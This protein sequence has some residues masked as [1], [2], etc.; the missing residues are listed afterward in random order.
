MKLDMHCHTVA[1]DGVNT[2][3]ELIVDAKN[4]WSQALFITDHDRVSLDHVDSIRE[5]GLI[6]V[7][8]VEI[9]TTDSERLWE[10]WK[11]VHMTYY[12]NHYSQELLD[13]LARK[14]R[15]K[16]EFISEFVKFLRERWLDISDEEFYGT[17]YIAK[18]V[19]IN[20]DN[21][22]KLEELWI[23]SESEKERRTL[24]YKWFLNKWWRFYDDFLAERWWEYFKPELWDIAQLVAWKWILSFAHPNFTFES[25]Q[26][27]WFLE[28]YRNFYLPSLWITAIEINT[29][30]SKKWV[31]AIIWLKEDIPNIQL[32]FWSDCH[33]LWKPDDKHWDL[34]FENDFLVEEVVS[35][36]FWNFR[37]RLWI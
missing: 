5:A 18:D 34:W 12:A 27:T 3:D 9:T 23:T 15:E 16:Q 7:P 28:L 22:E 29:R 11:D 6:T 17:Y 13:I 35:R 8:S 14:E 20:P 32:T 25:Q 1:S 37:E 31:E 36:E 26:I 24:F 33:R 10:K 4:K 21:M 30:A 19:S 2:R